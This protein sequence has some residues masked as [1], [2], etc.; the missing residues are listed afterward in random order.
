MENIVQKAKEEIKDV[1]LKAL[2]E[3]KKEGLLNFESIQDVEVEEPKEKQHGDLAT[4]FAM[5]MAR[6][7]KMAPRKIAEIIASKMNTSGTFIEK[8]EVAGPGFI[9]FFL[10]QNFLIETLKLIHKRGKDYGRVNLGKGK[11]V[12][13][14]FVSAN[15]TGPM[16]MGNARGGAIG[17][18]LASIL[19]YAGYNVSREFYI[20]DAGNQIE[21]F[22]YSLEARYLQLLGID[23]EVPEGGYHGEDII[24]RAKEFLEIHGDKYKDV[25]SEERRKALIEYGLKKNIEKMKEDLVLYGIEYDVW[26]SEQSLYDSG[27][28]YKV[29]E[30]LT[31]KGYTYEKD[32]ALWFKMTLF[33]AEKDDVLVRSNGVPTYLASDIAYHKNKF[34]TRGFDWVIN[35]WGADHH[36]HV[37]PMKGAMKALGIDP[38]RLDVVLMQLVKLIEG[39]QVVR[40]SKR[41]GKMITLR[42]LIEEVGKDAARFF[43]N[44]RSPDSPIEFDLDLAKQQTNENPVFY[45][46][47][48]HARICSIIRQ[49]EEM[50]VKIENIEDVDL[51]LLKEEEE[52]D[53]I[54]KLA[55]FPEEI[56]I[57]AK[58]LAPHR[59][60]RYVIDVASLFHSFYNSHRVKGAEENLMKA[61]FALILAVKTVLKNALDILKVTAPE[62]M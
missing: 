49:L 54:K 10:N 53:L 25:P 3:A 57:A 6:E 23:A 27:E 21:K 7:A 40:M 42:D 1:V 11:K 35:V 33:G 55:Y 50:G 18:V 51:G 60:T 31:E 32:G 30:E 61:R 44:M 12:Q 19:D 8:V 59:I 46:Q 17:D 58:T 39:G 36:G 62:R 20:N 29:I 52:V 34:V 13:V 5:V 26:F 38:N 14:E 22:G 41:T 9:N 48:A 24:D 4:N 15:P 47:Y 56:T 37:A 16:H 2:N 28:V 43:F 45:V